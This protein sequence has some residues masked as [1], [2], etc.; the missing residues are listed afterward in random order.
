M[1][2]L[3]KTL[4][5]FFYAKESFSFKN[6]VNTT[7]LGGSYNEYLLIDEVCLLIDEEGFIARVKNGKGFKII[8]NDKL[9]Y[10]TI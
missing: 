10:K 6:F 7:G 8:F 4:L 3:I 1:K 2:N 9:F 5:L